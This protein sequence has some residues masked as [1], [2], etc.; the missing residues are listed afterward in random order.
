MTF[1]ID[2]ERK[3]LDNLY[4]RNVLYTN[5]ELQ[6]VVMNLLPNEEI[7]REKHDG[8]QFIRVEEGSGVAIVN[9][10]RYLLKDGSAIVID[11]GKYH[12]IITGKNGLK[13]YSIY[14]PPQ[15]EHGI[16][17]KYKID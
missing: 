13:L 10:K 8:S 16:K 7:G 17:E 3:T 12:N 9:N 11:S 5:N 4:Y 15:H 14:S 1:K 2:I 6:I